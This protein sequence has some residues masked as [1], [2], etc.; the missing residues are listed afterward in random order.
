[1]N[2]HIYFKQNS[3]RGYTQ[4]WTDSRPVLGP[5]EASRGGKRCYRGTFG[6]N[7]QAQQSLFELDLN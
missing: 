6:L 1:M 5:H 3:S 2:T 4:I 7:I